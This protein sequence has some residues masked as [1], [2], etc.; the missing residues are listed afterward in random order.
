MGTSVSSL[1]KIDSASRLSRHLMPYMIHI[2]SSLDDCKGLSVKMWL[3]KKK[4]KGVIIRYQEI[5]VGQKQNYEA[6][7]NFISLT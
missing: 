1:I 7:L 4:T 5:L 6:V 3:K 2:D